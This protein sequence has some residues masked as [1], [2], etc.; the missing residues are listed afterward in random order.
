[1]RRQGAQ[2]VRAPPALVQCA[3]QAGNVGAREAVLALAETRGGP[4]RQEDVQCL[5]A[6]H[7]AQELAGTCRIQ[8]S[9][10]LYGLPGSWQPALRLPE[11]S[12]TCG[13]VELGVRE[14][15]AGG[16]DLVGR[17]GGEPWGVVPC[18][19]RSRGFSCY[20]L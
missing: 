11:P 19:G 8:T 17:Q 5:Q 18:G 3:P 15:E 9:R 10:D 12:Q 1:M 6:T 13:W 16:Q 4:R 7:P 2:Q 14:S 20:V